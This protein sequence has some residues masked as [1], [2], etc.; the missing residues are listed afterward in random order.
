MNNVGNVLTN[1]FLEIFLFLLLKIPKSEFCLRG[2]ILLYYLTID[3]N[4]P[5]L[6]YKNKKN[7]TNIDANLPKYYYYVIVK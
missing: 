2:N 4:P 3:K 1:F 7:K 6:M 5:L